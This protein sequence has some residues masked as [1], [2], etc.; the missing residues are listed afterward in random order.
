MLLLVD[1]L[2]L[3]CGFV[4]IVDTKEYENIQL[5]FQTLA[6]TRDLRSGK[7]PKDVFIENY[8]KERLPQL[9]SQALER[10]FA[11][12]SFN[13]KEYIAFD[14]FLQAKYLLDHTPHEPQIQILK[15]A[16]E[17]RTPEEIVWE[18]RL[19]FVFNLFDWNFDQV[20]T[21]RGIEN[22]MPLLMQDAKKQEWTLEDLEDYNQWF[23]HIAELALLEFDITNHY[24]QLN[25]RSFRKLARN[26]IIIQDILKMLEPK[27]DDYGVFK[28]SNMV[29]RQED[30]KQRKKEELRAK[31]QAKQKAKSKSKSQ[32]QQQQQPKQADEL[33]Q[34]TGNE[35]V[36]VKT[37]EKKMKNNKKMLKISCLSFIFYLLFMLH[38]HHY[39]SFFSLFLFYI[40]CNFHLI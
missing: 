33:V 26:D 24:N 27:V 40:I 10:F 12:L 9:C 17:L 37:L 1:L 22:M 5:H 18:D 16:D 14:E 21:L 38:T 2:G 34:S 28:Y 6:K 19:R 39:L 25:W 8:L 30:S 31:K 15:S 11:V 23:R 3:C 36:C 29:K 7:I 13:G 32:Q 4:L 20:I 35:M